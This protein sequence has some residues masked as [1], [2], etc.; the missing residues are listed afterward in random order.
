MQE[1]GAGDPGVPPGYVREVV[2]AAPRQLLSRQS[3]SATRCSRRHLTLLGQEAVAMFSYALSAEGRGCPGCVCM[4]VCACTHT[5]A[6]AGLAVVEAYAV[7]IE[8]L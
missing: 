8:P 4:C 3:L 2:P 1:V 6:Q 5:N 7:P